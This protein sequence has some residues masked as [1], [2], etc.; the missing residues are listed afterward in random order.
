M[1]KTL[2]YRE[3]ERRGKGRKKKKT[4]KKRKRKTLVMET[5]TMAEVKDFQHFPE[6]MLPHTSWNCCL[7]SLFLWSASIDTHL[8]PRV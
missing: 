6:K 4:E 1:N 8:H 7:F 3:R 5:E 2:S